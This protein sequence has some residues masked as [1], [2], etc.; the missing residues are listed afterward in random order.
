MAKK[1][2]KIK[3]SIEMDERGIVTERLVTK[4]NVTEDEERLFWRILENKDK[5]ENHFLNRK[6]LLKTFDEVFHF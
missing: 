2:P 1:E 4:D 6:E 5:D 3:Y